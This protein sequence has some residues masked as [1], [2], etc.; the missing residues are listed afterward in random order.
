MVTVGSDAHRA[1]DMGRDIDVAVDLA[2][3][4]GFDAIALFEGRV[5]RM[6]PIEK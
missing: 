2:R 1:T 4:A 6:L 5:P 3:A